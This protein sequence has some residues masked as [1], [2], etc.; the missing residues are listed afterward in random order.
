MFTPNDSIGG[1]SGIPPT[2][3]PQQ[4]GATTPTY[5]S[6][7]A[8]FSPA[9]NPFT[10]FMQQS[11]MQQQPTNLRAQLLHQQQT[12]VIETPQCSTVDYIVQVNGFGS[13]E[14]D[15]LREECVNNPYVS[16][17]VHVAKFLPQ[18]VQDPGP[19]DRFKNVNGVSH[20]VTPQGYLLNAGSQ[21]DLQHFHI[22]PLCRTMPA[23]LLLNYSES[24][25]GGKIKIKNSINRVVGWRYLN[26]DGQMVD[27][28]SGD[29]PTDGHIMQFTFMGDTKIVSWGDAGGLEQ[30]LAQADGRKFGIDP[31]VMAFIR[32]QLVHDAKDKGVRLL[33]PTTSVVSTITLCTHA[34]VS[35]LH[36]IISH[37]NT[38]SSYP[39]KQSQLQ[40]QPSTN[41]PQPLITEPSNNRSQVPS[42]LSMVRSHMMV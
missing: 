8:P 22:R 23:K 2:P 16:A 9:V 30:K 14:A 26:V 5:Q 18:Y 25:S 12:N 32:S 41:Q 7:A 28:F 39:S 40:A 37:T 27:M 13:K 24:F 17:W 38:V 31:T 10:P 34:F 20:Y 15:K 1:G 36:Y 19:V 42:S 4:R 6:T 33:L 21:Q 3:L 11:T 29:D 35:S